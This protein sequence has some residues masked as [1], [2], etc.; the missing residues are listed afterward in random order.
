VSPW[1]WYTEL[2]SLKPLI[3][4]ITAFTETI[5]LFYPAAGMTRHH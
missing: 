1:A 5:G 2:A 4:I 3:E